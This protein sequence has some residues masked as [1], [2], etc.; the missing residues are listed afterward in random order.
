MK[1]SAPILASM[2]VVGQAFDA[3]L[4]S[5]DTFGN[6]LS[7]DVATFES[8]R[9]FS[10]MI[11]LG[12]SPSTLASI[13]LT[14]N[15]YGVKECTFS[16]SLDN[17]DKYF[18]K[19]QVHKIGKLDNICHW[20]QVELDDKKN[21]IGTIDA[22]E[23]NQFKRVA[24]LYVDCETED[25]TLEAQKEDLAACVTKTPTIEGQELRSNT[26]N[27]KRV[28]VNKDFL[29]MNTGLVHFSQFMSI[30]FAG[31][32]PV[33]D[34]LLD[35][36]NLYS[37]NM[38]KDAIFNFSGLPLST[39][40]YPGRTRLQKS[41][42]GKQNPV[43]KAQYEKMR[44]GIEIVGYTSYWSQVLIDMYNIYTNFDN[45]ISWDN[46]KWV[47]YQVIKGTVEFNKEF[48]M[49]KIFWF[50]AYYAM[51]E[52]ISMVMIFI[53][54]DEMPYWLP[55]WFPRA[56]NEYWRVGTSMLTLNV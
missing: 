48:Y 15:T 3:T 25:A 4:V 31:G 53:S 1:Y 46:D 51:L 7:R 16:M 43:T 20:P 13:S 19:G 14:T 38:V 49:E 18:E 6:V 47:M 33:V 9:D 42:N 11:N 37:Y 35:G 28:F 29:L 26:F 2:A 56:L 55:Y 17:Q 52:T 45:L 22:R 40:E 44:S 12:V 24:T 50:N 36:M 23:M 8:G 21:F 30:A 39:L 27:F 34:A 10:T 5:K 54:Y 32:N 41:K